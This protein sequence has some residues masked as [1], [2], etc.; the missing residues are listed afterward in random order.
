MNPKYKSDSCPLCG[1]VYDIRWAD[2]DITKCPKCG[3]PFGKK[4]NDGYV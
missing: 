4:V 1:W 3:H 2:Y